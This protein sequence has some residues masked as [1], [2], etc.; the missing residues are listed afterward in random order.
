VVEQPALRPQG[1]AQQP[2]VAIE[3][4]VTDVLGHPDRRDRVV[5]LAAD[6]A[7]V[8]QADL[9]P[10]GDARLGDALAGPLGLRLADG[11]ADRRHV[12]VAGGV[13]D[14]RPPTAADVEEAPPGHR[15]EPELAADEVVLQR[16]GGREVGAVVDEPGARIRHRRAEHEAV[17]VVADVVVVLDRGRVPPGRVAPAVE[18]GLERWWRQRPAEHAEAAGC[19]Q[20]R[21]QLADGAPEVLGERRPQRLDE[22]EDVAVGVELTGDV[23]PRQPQ[24]VGTPQEPPER[25]G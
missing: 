4:L 11:D 8:L 20:G 22:L 15:V 21:G 13:D 10:V 1:A 6:G 18:A 25:V 23:R 7:V 14:H 19:P 12:V 3:V 17:E 16:L 9:D 24:L 5:L 2:V